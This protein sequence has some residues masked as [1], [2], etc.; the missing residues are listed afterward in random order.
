MCTGVA[1]GERAE[2]SMVKVMVIGERDKSY[3]AAGVEHA[4]A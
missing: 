1:F 3:E 2:R 4:D